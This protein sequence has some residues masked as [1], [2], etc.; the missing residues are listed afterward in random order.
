MANLV[1]KTLDHYNLLKQVGKGGMA[2]VYLAKDTRNSREVALKVLSPSI[3]EEK[4]F[5][6]RFRREAGLVVRLKHPHIV[7][8]LDYGETDGV[9]YLVMPYVKGRTL[10][11]VIRRGGLSPEHI[12]QWTDQVAGALDYAHRQGIIHRDIKPSNVLISDSGQAMLMDFGLAKLA[13]R[14]STLTGSMLMGTPAY[15]SPE[16]GRGQE[17]DQ[18]SDQYAFGIMLFQILTG[19]LP[20]ESDN[21]MATVLRHLQEPVPSLRAINPRVPQTVENIVR[22][23]LSK[24]PDNR[25]SSVSEL[26]SLFQ[27]AMRGKSIPEIDLPTEMLEQG[28]VEPA[29]PAPIARSTRPRWLIPAVLGS[30]LVIAIIVITTMLG[31]GE[32]EPQLPTMTSE[33]IIEPA[34][35][36]ILPS[37]TPQ[38]TSAPPVTSA[39]CPGVSLL[40]LPPQGNQAVWLLD[41]LTADTLVLQDLS[42]LQWPT[43]NGDLQAIYL[44]D[45]VV[46]NP[47]GEGGGS[48]LDDA[49]RTIAPQTSL[50]L[51]LEFTWEAGPGG[52]A[53]DLLFD[54]GCQLSGAW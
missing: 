34:E 9:V 41:N 29:E 17:L 42:G 5:V 37:P 7:P 51:R 28:P 52:Y 25:F 43:A 12:L 1:G 44:G 27:A 24:Q 13:D 49:R 45:E 8:V 4:R 35:G 40:W 18:R 11:D 22:K 30:L 3:S 31:G 47:D 26:N 54:S 50:Q 6:R 23:S 38:P 19:Q 53:F 36:I 20:F 16:Q 14:S 33:T 39:D 46:W 21:P 10:A 2:T 48:W 32:P 15:I